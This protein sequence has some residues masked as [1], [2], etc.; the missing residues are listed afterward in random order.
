MKPEFPHDGFARRA[1]VE[2]FTTLPT[3][4]LYT[5]IKNGKFPRPIK[6]GPGR[7]GGAVWDARAVR[8]WAEERIRKGDAA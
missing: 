1:A 6:L 5:M 7:M 4:T 2:K 8:A 3:S